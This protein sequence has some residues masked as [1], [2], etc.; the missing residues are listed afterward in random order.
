MHG[1]TQPAD[2]IGRVG[3]VVKFSIEARGADLSNQRQV[4]T[5]GGTSW[6]NSGAAGST[7]AEIYDFDVTEAR[8]GRL[9][10]CKITNADGDVI[11]SQPG[12]II[13][14]PIV[15]DTQPEDCFGELGDPVA[16]SVEA[17]GEGLSYQ[18][19]L[20][21]NN[22]SS[23][24][25]S[26]GAGCTTPTVYGFDIAESRLGRLYRCKITD[27]EGN[28]LYSEPG[29]IR[30]D[31]LT[32]L[33]Q[34]EDYVGRVGDTVWFS[35]EARGTG[36]TYQWQVSTNGGTS[37]G[38]STAG[39]YKTPNAS[40]LLAE[41]N[42]GYLYRCKVTDAEG[43][44][45]YSEPGEI[46]LL[47]ETWEYTYNADGLRTKRTNGSTTYN[48]IYNG[49]SLSQMTVGSN[50]LYFAYDAS[51]TPMSVTYNGTNYYY[52][53]NIQGDVTAILN[54]SGT[55]VVQYTYDAWGKILTTTGSM[56][57]TLGVHNPLR[58]RGY[59]YD[60]ET[61][62]YYLQSRYYNPAMGR[63]ISADS[64]PTTGQ[65]LLGNN[66]FAYCGNNP[67]IRIDSSGQFFNTICGAIVGAIISAATRQE[68][69]SMGDAI[70]RGMVTGAIAGA[71]LDICVATGGAAAGLLIAGSLGAS[72]AM[73]DTAW[74]A[75]NNGRKAS[76]GDI[77]LSG[78]VGGG[79]N[80]LFGAAGREFS[81]AVGRAVK[82][83]GKAIWD[84]TVRS[85][86]NK[87]GKVVLKKV[88]I[89]TAK[90]MASS[91]IQGGFGKIYTMVGSKMMEAF[92]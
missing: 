22:G 72:A 44:V 35:I 21:Y 81:N 85:I 83:V 4:S 11:Y 58:Y 16:F 20:S 52:A 56:A 17:R 57:S 15:I 69:E 74:E 76:V 88:V 91:T 43:N 6:G 14:A 61:T 70:V 36:L 55:A 50:T 31:A 8:V 48:Y 66:M 18:W 38:N 64:Y 33:S 27:N 26:T 42:P 82:T 5:N 7:T 28:V 67:T 40:L 3:D 47:T 75:H 71:G 80:V 24:Y 34:P 37:W 29:E 23:W 25:D 30:L 45:A 54:S 87:S 63:F 79:L 12:E 73:A 65:G 89:E 1:R 9:Y 10:R 77:F 49:S 51:G 32:I 86:T 19:E 46:I 60:T 13:A 90:N 41:H 78:V 62:L 39:G 53:T 68:N 84:N 59:V 92:Q 2:F